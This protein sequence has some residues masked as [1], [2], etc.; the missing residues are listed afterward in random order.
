MNMKL[1]LNFSLVLVSFGLFSV[2]QSNPQPSAGKIKISF[3]QNFFG[4]FCH[5]KK[6]HFLGLSA[7]QGGA[8]FPL[9]H[10][11]GSYNAVCNKDH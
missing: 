6:M 4:S 1:F 5:L 7:L 11:H 10:T 3:F 2:T 8:V 9:F